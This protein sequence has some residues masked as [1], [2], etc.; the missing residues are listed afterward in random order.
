MLSTIHSVDILPMKYSSASVSTE[1]TSN[2]RVHVET[3][4]NTEFQHV[5]GLDWFASVC[6]LCCKCMQ[7]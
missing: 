2:T 7:Y 1:G 5:D 3:E 4:S 6:I